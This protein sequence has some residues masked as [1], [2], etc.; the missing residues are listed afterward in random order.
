MARDAVTDPAFDRAGELA[1]EKAKGLILAR[2]ESGRVPDHMYYHNWAHTAGV[3]ERSLAIGV[4]LGMSDRHLLLTTVAAAFHDVVQRWVAVEHEGGVV[5]RQRF[6]GRDEV[7]SAAEAVEA[8]SELGVPFNAEERG[9]V[10]SAIIATIPGWDGAAST[11][12]QPFLIKH[13]VISAVALADVGAAGMA[14][15]MYFRDGPALFAEENLDLMITVMSAR[16]AAD[17]PRHVQD[18]YRARYLA[19]L[20]IQPGFAR[21]RRELMETRELTG[22]DAAS[23]E[24]VLALFG[25]FGESIALSEAAVERA[26]HLDFVPL[27]RTLDPRAFPDDAG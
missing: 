13:P 2:H 3:I 9:I 17:L 22:F 16:T 7:A 8:M 15:A 12:A 19:W 23:R 18:T 21:G 4:A 27:M 20:G 6:A 14:P 5:M 26:R 1:I 24:R 11:V 10:A 25:E